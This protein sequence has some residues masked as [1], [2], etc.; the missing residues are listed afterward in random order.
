[1]LTLVHVVIVVLVAEA[2][3]LA[4]ADAATRQALAPHVAAGAALVLAL[5]EGLV[6]GSALAVAGWL[7]AAGIAHAFGVWRI[8][9]GRRAVA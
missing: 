9:R 8:V 6:D 2:L 1:M 4:R 5:R 7:L 3:W